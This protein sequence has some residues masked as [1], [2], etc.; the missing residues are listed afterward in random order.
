M[1]CFEMRLNSL[2]AVQALDDQ[3]QVDPDRLRASVAAPGAANRGCDQE[4]ADTGHDQH[5]GDKEKLLGPDFNEEEVEAPVRHVDEDGL[6]R[7]M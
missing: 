3:E 5:S 6:I 4:Q 1:T 7:R 2:S